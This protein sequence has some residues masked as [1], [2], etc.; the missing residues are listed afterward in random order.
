[1]SS[2]QQI[3]GVPSTSST[4]SPVADAAALKAQVLLSSKIAT[5]ET[6]PSWWGAGQWRRLDTPALRPPSP[7]ARRTGATPA[8]PAPAAPHLCRCPGSVPPSQDRPLGSTGSRPAEGSPA[9]LWM[10]I[11]LIVIHIGSKEWK[12]IFYLTNI[13]IWFCWVVFN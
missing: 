11:L 3:W 8:P 1:M 10:Y 4:Y 12:H 13:M 2:P 5:M 7:W 6:W 9:E